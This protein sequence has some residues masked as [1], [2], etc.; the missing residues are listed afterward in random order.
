MFGF[1]K[2]TAKWDPSLER[3]PEINVEAIAKELSVDK[4]GKEDGSQDQPPSEAML[5]TTV[6][7]SAVEQV[8]KLRREA[9]TSYELELQ[10]L[11]QR[12]SSAKSDTSEIR[13]KIGDAM[14]AL[15]R[16][17]RQEE[18]Q[19]EPAR[20][21]VVAYREKVERF[22]KNHDAI[23]PPKPMRSGLFTMSFIALMLAVESSMNG[24]FFA[25]QN[26][27]GLVGGVSQA[28][29]ISL[30]NVAVGFGS[31]FFQRYVNL[32][33]W[34]YKFIGGFSVVA[35]LVFTIPFNLAV[36]HFRNSLEGNMD[37]EA[38][39]RESIT[40]TL[41]QPFELNSLSSWSLFIVGAIISF[42]SFLKGAW[43]GD[44]VPGF[45]AIWDQSEMAL[46]RYTDAF[47][48]GHAALD[49]RF[50]EEREALQSEV[51]S[52]RADLRAA[53]DA[54]L[55]RKSMSSGLDV[56]LDTADSAANMLLKRY[57][58]ANQKARKTTAP[59]Y[60]HEEFR[61][62]R[63]QFADLDEIGFGR[64]LVESEIKRM[65]RL[66]EV[67]V[68]HLMQAQKRSLLAFPAI[69]EIRS[70]RTERKIVEGEDPLQAMN[71]AIEDIISSEF[72]APAA[73]SLNRPSV[74][75]DASSDSTATESPEKPKR[76]RQTHK[77][78]IQSANTASSQADT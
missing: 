29:M 69:D 25:E 56:F 35:W 15:E 71:K 12:V 22:V 6:E 76:S 78:R 57:R 28:F 21:E 65:E 67:G 2:R 19:L 33:G 23:A 34:F 26:K 63:P 36:A 13:L 11:R 75:A 39:L 7:Q 30:I 74:Q 72:S 4:R 8:G 70:G 32:R 52:R 18:L 60:F 47:N 24:I 43:I 53:T 10:A 20:I 54:L 58:E 16:L 9:L 41:A 17:Q 61:F 66:V 62:E 40:L 45:N 1:I 3:F 48:S 64:E 55:S 46:N 31:G 68:A 27:M 42:L 77:P 44:P 14:A 59:K 51:E 73:A 37:W 50:M 5:L 49:E 38:A